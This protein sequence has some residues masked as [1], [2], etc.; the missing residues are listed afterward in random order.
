MSGVVSDDDAISLRTSTE[1]SKSGAAPPAPPAAS[2][3]SVQTFESERSEDEVLYPPPP[4]RPVPMAN[5]HEALP[6]ASAAAGAKAAKSAFGQLV[7]RVAAVLVSPLYFDLQDVTQ[8]TWP[9]SVSGVGGKLG[10][11][12]G[13]RVRCAWNNI[14]QIRGER[15][16]WG[17]KLSGARAGVSTRANMAV[18]LV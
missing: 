8:I 13:H 3:V 17:S 16:S 18:R 6:D 5:R 1:Y 11:Q 2:S 4:A 7:E 9:G 12:Q 15:S 10:T 14:A